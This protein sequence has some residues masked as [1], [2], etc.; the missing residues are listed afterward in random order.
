MFKVVAFYT[1]DTPYENEIEILK[2]SLK[3]HKIPHIIK[4][5]ES[6]GNWVLNAGA[7]PDFLLDILND[8]DHD[9]LYVDADAEFTCY[10]T[11]F[12]DLQADIALHKRNG[13]EVLSGTIFIKN[14][15]E[16]K[17]VISAWAAEQRRKPF[18]WDQKTLATILKAMENDFDFYELPAEYTKIFDKMKDVQ[19]PIIIHNQASRRFKKMIK[20]KPR[21]LHVDING[22]RGRVMSDG[23]I[24]FPRLNNQLLKD[25]K[26][27]YIRLPNQNR[28]FK[29]YQGDSKSFSSIESQFR[30][31]PVYIIGK[32]P[33]L[34]RVSEDVFRDDSP[35]LCINEAIKHVETLDL[36]NPLYAVQ[37]DH[38]LKNGCLPA[39]GGIFVSYRA[40]RAYDDFEDKYVFYPEHFNCC[41]TT[42]T[43]L[44][45]MRIAS[46]LGSTRYRMLAFDGAL[47]KDTRYASCVPY[48]STSGGKPERFYNHGLRIQ[49]LAD[50]LRIPLAFI[51][52]DPS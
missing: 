7:K 47:K 4:G 29:K 23:T 18:L 26:R 51:E 38:Q 49:A 8:V 46:S 45:A 44:V 11:I 34:D 25:L 19:N 36:S 41:R 2:A 9:I 33:S 52:L 12:D 14:R 13:T 43:V 27:D 28:F 35:I 32:G 6:R 17:A 20:K 5:I 15:N 39:R 1:K 31:R 16:A 48:K 22:H 3:K 50:R 40:R 30:G 37:Q 10:P 24:Y 42:L 21:K